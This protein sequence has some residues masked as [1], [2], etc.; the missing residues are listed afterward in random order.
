MLYIALKIFR[1][2]HSNHRRKAGTSSDY[3]MAVSLSNKCYSKLFFFFKKN[4][5]HSSFI[6]CTSEALLSKNL[7]LKEIALKPQIF[8]KLLINIIYSLSAVTVSVRVV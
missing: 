1:N 3:T 6:L 8:P 4:T 2:K 5:G 7:I